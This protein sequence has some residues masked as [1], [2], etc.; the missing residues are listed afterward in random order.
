MIK[1]D[2]KRVMMTL[3]DSNPGVALQITFLYYKDLNEAI[4]FYEN[5]LGFKLAIDQGWSKIYHVTGNAHIGLV[6]ETRGRFNNEPKKTNQ[7]CLRCRMWK[8]GIIIYLPEVL[9]T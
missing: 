2:N 5:V 8:R 1:I 6:D 3:E 4:Q 7:I 9:E